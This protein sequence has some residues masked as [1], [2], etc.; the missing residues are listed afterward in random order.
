[1]K[2]IHQRQQNKKTWMKE[3]EKTSI[4]KDQQTKT[5]HK[6]SAKYKDIYLKR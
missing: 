5:R 4:K 6:I 3:K 1:M 2:T